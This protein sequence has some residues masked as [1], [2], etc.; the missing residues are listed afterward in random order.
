MFY[1]VADIHMYDASLIS[2]EGR[3]KVER[4]EKELNALISNSMNYKSSYSKSARQM[5]SEAM[6]AADSEAAS[7][8][9]IR[10]TVVESSSKRAVVA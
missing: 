9:K 4:L 1:Q 2:R 5:A 3:S 8:K 10:K 6:M 7:S